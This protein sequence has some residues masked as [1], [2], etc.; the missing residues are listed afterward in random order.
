MGRSAFDSDGLR[1]APRSPGLGLPSEDDDPGPQGDRGAAAASPVR[2][3]AW[4]DRSGRDDAQVRASPE[5]GPGLA[6]TS[7]DPGVRR[8]GLV[9]PHA[10]P[11][12]SDAEIA[13]LFGLAPAEIPHG[14]APAGSQV[15]KGAPPV[16]A[17]VPA[18]RAAGAPAISARAAA[19]APDAAAPSAVAPSAVAPSGAALS[20]AALSGTASDVPADVAAPIT[21]DATATVSTAAPQPP[22]GAATLAAPAGAAPGPAAVPPDPGPSPRPSPAAVKADAASAPVL[23]AG[24]P[25]P[26]PPAPPA[27]ADLFAALDASPAVAGEG[28]QAALLPANAPS[29]TDLLAEHRARLRG[30]FLRAGA[31]SVE[32]YEMLEL[33]LFRAI[34]RRD[35]KPIAKRLLKAFGDFNHVISAPPRRLAEITGMGEA[36]VTELKIVEAAAHRLAQS[37]VLNRDAIQSW[38]QLTAYLRQR[39]AHEDTEQFRVLFLDRRNVLIAD[40]AQARGTVDHVPVYPREVV[41]RALD[42]GASALVLVH[43]HPSGDPT[44]S[45]ADVDMTRRVMEAC[46]T[47]SV[48][49]HDHVVVGRGGVASFHALGL[50]DD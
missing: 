5:H 14:A 15:A 28:P 13:E 19:P 1:E 22:A 37:R 17:P 47:V 32:D 2:D 11:S 30:R 31:E 9:R 7:S 46:R 18:S 44:P 26:S 39:L 42:L 38:D 33:I 16:T 25:S 49:L 41:R 3:H 12:L 43:N 40:E 27:S 6:E 20:G 4:P 45:R 10:V 36:A 8:R 48:T 23:P 35:V 21:G 29:D 24:S 34:P 50:L